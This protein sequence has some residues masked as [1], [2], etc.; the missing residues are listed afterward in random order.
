MV[1]PVTNRSNVLKMHLLCPKTI[2]DGSTL[3]V[4]T[5]FL[6]K[7][8]V[9]MMSHSVGLA[10]LLAMPFHFYFWFGL[11]FISY[12]GTVHCIPEIP[13]PFQKLV[14]PDLLHENGQ[15]HFLFNRNLIDIFRLQTINKHKSMPEERLVVSTSYTKVKT[16]SACSTCFIYQVLT[17]ECCLT[18]RWD[19][20]KFNH[21][22]IY[23]VNTSF[24]NQ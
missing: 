15:C 16:G 11:L 2:P 22:K 3:T 13:Q 1:L 5:H 23:V 14:Y 4:Y 12:C 17:A 10:T 18:K 7:L 8:Q 9:V 19:L 6:P 20:T 21:C 24:K